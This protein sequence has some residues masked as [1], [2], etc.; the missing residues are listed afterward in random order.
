MQAYGLYLCMTAL[1]DPLLELKI[2]PGFLLKNPVSTEQQYLTATVAQ[3]RSS[4]LNNSEDT[5][6]FFWTNTKLSP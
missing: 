6:Y 1:M 5:I 4:R 2:K 3:D